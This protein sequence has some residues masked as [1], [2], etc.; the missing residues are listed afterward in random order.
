MGRSDW[1][2]L[3]E[4]CALVERDKSTVRRWRALGL[5]STWQPFRAVLY[6]RADLLRVEGEMAARI[7]APT[8]GRDL[9]T[10]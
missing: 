5:V 9:V 10:R 2:S 4:A 6:S 3:A 8:F 7:A 1:V